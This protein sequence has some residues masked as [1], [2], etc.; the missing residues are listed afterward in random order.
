M[1]FRRFSAKRKM[2]FKGA[3]HY[4][5]ATEV[6]TIIDPHDQHTRTMCPFTLERFVP[7]GRH[8][9]YRAP[10]RLSM[11]NLPIPAIWEVVECYASLDTALPRASQAKQDTQYRG[12]TLRVRDRR[13]NDLI[14]ADIL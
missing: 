8:I 12:C 6:G 9:Y 7:R 13:T 5:E 3:T 1:I 2:T 4:A 11:A 10:F 14:M